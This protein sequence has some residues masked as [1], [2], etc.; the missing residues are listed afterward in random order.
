MADEQ[1]SLTSEI[2]KDFLG[3]R[4]VLTSARGSR[5]HDNAPPERKMKSGD[6][7][8]CFFCPGNE[9][10]TPPEIDRIE[11]AGKW[12]IRCFPNKFPAFSS[13]SRKA[14]GRHEVI[15]ETDR[16]ELQLWDLP[17]GEVKDILKTYAMRIELLHQMPGV[18][19]VSVFKNSGKEAGT[20]IQHSHSQ[21]IATSFLPKLIRHHHHIIHHWQL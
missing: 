16:H 19:Y 15:V 6:P 2:R 18:Q 17:Q 13:E 3:R 21:I 11:R 14:Y 1:Q 9:H 5:P 8:K 4:V 7:S 10:L 20:S 12:E